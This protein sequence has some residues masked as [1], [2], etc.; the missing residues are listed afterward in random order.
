MLISYSNITDCCN[1]IKIVNQNIKSEIDAIR[2]EKNKVANGTIWSSPA[3]SY[4]ATKLNNILTSFDSAYTSL[5]NYVTLMNQSVANYESI[6][7]Q[8]AQQV[9]RIFK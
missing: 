6:D 3:S 7:K 8:V 2:N 9:A 1:D 5:N 4:Y